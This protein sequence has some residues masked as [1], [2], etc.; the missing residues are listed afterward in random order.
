MIAGVV[1]AAATIL[2]TA[3]GAEGVGMV[4]GLTAAAVEGGT[5]I[6]EAAGVAMTTAAVTMIAGVVAAAAMMTA[7]GVEGVGMAGAPAVEGGTGTMIA[8]VAGVDMTNAVVVE[9]ADTMTAGV[10]VDTTS[11]VAA[12][13]VAVT[14]IARAA[15]AVEGGTEGET[16]ADGNRVACMQRQYSHGRRM[17]GGGV[18]S[19]A[20]PPVAFNRFAPWGANAWSIGCGCTP[21][22]QQCCGRR[23]KTRKTILVS[24]QSILLF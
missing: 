12:A 5:M 21:P 9:G 14:M 8:E 15:A 10:A 4:G 3:V 24:T 2:T 20:T 6:A 22:P 13:A 7:V 18:K 11:A 17:I 19:A 1:A 16:M 23:V